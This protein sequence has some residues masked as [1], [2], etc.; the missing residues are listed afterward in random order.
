MALNSNTELSLVNTSANA[1]SITLPLISTT[2]GRVLSFKDVVGTFGKK[3]LTLNT[4]GSDTFEDGGTTKVLRESYGSIQI[5]G[6]SGKWY[7]LNGTQVNTL[8]LSTLNTIA[9]STINLSTLNTQIS[10]LNFIDNRVSTNTLYGAISSVLTQAVSTNFLYY[11]NYIIAGTRVGYATNLNRYNFIV[12]QIPG[13][14]LWI[15][16]ADSST[17][18][19]DTAGTQPVT[20]NGDIVR[21]IND[22][23]GNS[24]YSTTAA[25]T[26]I[27]TTAQLNGKSSIQVPSG[28]GF[29]TI[30]FTVSITNTVSL[31]LLI[32]TAS[33]G[34]NNITL[35]QNNTT[36]V[37]LRIQLEQTLSRNN[38]NNNSLN[39]SAFITNYGV[40]NIY[41][42]VFD[43]V[44]LSAYFNGS[45]SGTSSGST[46]PL[47]ATV[48][49]ALGFATGAI[50]GYL[51]EILVFNRF[52]NT[53][54]R[55]QVEGYLAWKWAQQANLPA[56]HPYKNS[57][58]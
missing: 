58:P 16:S 40:P 31:F 19:K 29:A 53:L 20:T 56:N 57:P 50:N 44:T 27:Y 12:V 23:S 41:C 17:L 24:Y 43:S 28:S 8:Q 36:N 4:S 46:T 1:G 30:P 48:N 11:N 21:R 32:Q 18:F 33:G 52:L 3:T 26:N 49:S 45:A 39:A 37:A 14:L 42:I 25:T 13:L 22:K 35:F 7:I 51:Y 38:A 2:P 9:I 10:S 15:D 54:Q 55:Q 34:S 5:V 6:N 47:L